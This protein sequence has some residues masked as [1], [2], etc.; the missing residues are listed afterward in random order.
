MRRIVLVLTVIVASVAT[1]ISAGESSGLVDRARELANIITVSEHGAH[2]ETLNEALDYLAAVSPPP[3]EDNRFIIR[4]G[5]GVFQGPVEM[6]EWVN[7]EGSGRDATVIT[8]GGSDEPLSAHTL[9]GANNAELSRLTVRSVG[10]GANYAVGIRCFGT[11]PALRDLR[12]VATGAGVFSRGIYGEYSSMTLE[13]VVIRAT[14]GGVADAF[15]ANYGAPSLEGVDVLAHSSSGDNSYGIGIGFGDG[16]VRITDSRIQVG[17]GPEDHAIGIN[18]DRSVGVILDGVDVETTATTISWALRLGSTP[19]V[20]VK[21]CTLIT[22]GD[23]T[24]SDAVYD[25]GSVP[26]PHAREF[27]TSILR[28]GRSSIYLQVANAFNLGASQLSGPVSNPMGGSARCVASYDQN[29]EPLTETCDSTSLPTPTPLAPTPTPT[30]T[31]V[32]TPTPTPTP[33]LTPTW[34]FFPTM[35]PTWTSTPTPSTP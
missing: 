8:A 21:N 19:E 12:V 7:I 6:M 33:T 35:T 2:F 4:I 27:T 5:P 34:T 18:L 26:A 23:A 17:L 11:S 32:V 14:D 13:D 1:G 31:W 20:T 30:R 3:A 16:I 15:R 10:I 9:L 25:S 29:F 28:G 22:K 24:A